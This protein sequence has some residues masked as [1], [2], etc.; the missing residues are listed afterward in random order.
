MKDENVIQ[1][2]CNKMKCNEMKCNSEVQSRSK[3]YL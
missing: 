2:V 3:R 1:G